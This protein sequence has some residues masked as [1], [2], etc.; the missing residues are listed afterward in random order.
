M[1][2]LHWASAVAVVCGTTIAGRAEEPIVPA[3]S[4]EC[5]PAVILPFCPPHGRPVPPPA[6]PYLPVDP[7]RPPTPGAPPSAMPPS[8]MPPSAAPPS[9]APTEPLTRA[10]EAGTLAATTFNPNMFGDLMSSSPLALSTTSSRFKTFVLSGF[11]PS[12]ARQPQQ[13][14]PY[15][16]TGFSAPS[17]VLV[18]S[19]GSIVFLEDNGGVVSFLAPQFRTVTPINAGSPPAVVPLQENGQVTNGLRTLNPGTAVVFLPAGSVGNLVNTDPSVY[20]LTQAY[21]IDSTQVATVLVPLP[22]G[23]GVVG[24]TK[25]AED[26]SPLPRDRVIFNVDYY[27]NTVLTPNGFDVTRFSPGIEKTFFDGWTSVEARFPFASTVDNVVGV[28]GLT[29]RAAEFGNINLTFKALVARSSDFAVATG[30]GLSLPTGPD[31]IVHTAGGGELLRVNNDSWIVTPYVAGLYAPNDRVFAQAWVQVGFDTT[32]SPVLFSPGGTGLVGVGRLH[33]QTLLSTDLQLGYWL[34]RNPYSSGLTGLA[35]FVELHYN[36]PLNDA[37]LIRANG[38]TIGSLINRYDEVNLTLGVAA[39]V[40]DNL[41]VSAGFVTP[42]RSAPDRFFD[43]QFGI[44]ANWLFGPAGPPPAC[45]SMPVAGAM[46]GTPGMPAMPGAPGTPATPGTPAEPMAPG[47]EPLTR[48]P[49]TGTL[50]STTFNPN[51]F[52]DQPGVPQGRRTVSPLPTT[53]VGG[54][55]AVRIPVMPRYGGLKPVENDGPRPLDRVYFSYNRYD[56]MNSSVMPAG[57]AEIWMNREVI[58]VETLIGPDASIGARLPFFQSGGDPTFEARDIGDLSLVGKYALVN[59]AAGNVISVG[60]T[61]TL[62]TGGRA[63][64]LWLLNDGT[65]AP[66]T[67]FVQPWG[68]AVLNFG[69]WFAQG[70]TSVVLPADPVYPIVWFNSAGVGYWLYRNPADGLLQ[71]V[72]P[73]AELHVNT[74]LT[75]RGDEAPI[76][77]ADQVNLT[78]GL[79][80]QFPRLTV[81]GAVCVPLAHPKPYDLE[82]MVSVNYRF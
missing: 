36:T 14:I 46:P 53:T 59:D 43:Y 10:P 17:D 22:A 19:T 60:M 2:R 49:E 61:L 20:F 62:P 16:P 57:M 51:F 75:N 39:V 41:L 50:A 73:V 4:R 79:Y 45:A 7:T 67:I 29:S 65:V 58:G 37:G 63:E 6:A 52:G 71:A 9:A 81:G 54:R 82:W 31:A 18:P 3:E 21:R 27:A 55:E 70:I 26:N 12:P 68:G 74:P 23:G 48:V 5:L 11:V 15:F 30:F 34:V 8:A 1:R 40:G 32:G 56:G 66:R 77:F 44:R 35:P 80:L 78:T 38:L 24:R 69:D 64:N 76:F 33:D 72:V 42:L 25:I 13:P 47:A 28:G